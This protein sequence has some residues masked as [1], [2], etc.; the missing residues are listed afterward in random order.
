[1]IGYSS[2]LINNILFITQ[3]TKDKNCGIG[4]IGKLIGEALSNS[5]K[6][7]FILKECNCI[8]D[9][10]SLISAYNPA[11]IIYNHHDIT[12]PWII[13]SNFTERYANIKHILIHHDF[14]QQRI[15]DFHPSAY[16][17]FKYIICPDPTLIGSNNVFPVNRLIPNCKIKK[18]TEKDRPIIG[19]Q[20]F[21]AVHKNIPK[22]A[23]K[24]IEE[25]DEAIINLQI[26]AAYFGSSI[27]DAKQRVEEVKNIIKNSGK[28]YIDLIFSHDLLST[29]DLVSLMSQN[30]INCYFNDYLDGAGLA[31]SPDYA[32]AAK[33][34]IALTKSHQF[35]NFLN[36]FPSIFIED[37]SLKDIINFGTDHLNSLYESY[38]EENI[39]KNYEDIIT[40][41]I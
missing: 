28:K 39:I 19:F 9:V 33:R 4:L 20:G 29:E 36:I 37:N 3:E 6:Y 26:P 16:F 40:K 30:T 31:S 17:G 10:D 15:N 21:G 11:A 24:T 34:P 38:S 22:I 41:L 25:F 27:H 14:H 7:N 5:K 2:K 32:L 1:M 23:L 13:Y 12:T 35:R 18:Y 8:G